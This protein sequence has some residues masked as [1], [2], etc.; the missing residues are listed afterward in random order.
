MRLLI[1]LVAALCLLPLKVLALSVPSLVSS[2]WLLKNLQDQQLAV[3]E[4]SDEASFDFEGHIPG[5]VNTNK[6]DWRYADKDGA[7]LHYSPQQLAEKIRTLGINHDDAVVIYYKGGDLNDVLGAFYLYWLFHYLGHTNV[8][9]LDQ[10]WHGWM[11]ANGP[12]EEASRT[13]SIGDF[14]ARPLAALEISLKELDEIRA[15]YLLIDGRFA[16]NFSGQKKFPANSLYGR[17]PGS[18]NFSWQEEYIRKS[19]DGHLYAQVPSLSTL[20]KVLGDE[21]DRP[22]LLICLGG[23]GAAVNYAMFYAAGYG[24]LRLNDAG[25]RGWNMR[26]LPLEKT[27]RNTL[28]LQKPSN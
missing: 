9:M 2:Q 6:S 27:E 16:A 20:K 28:K 25:F 4:V 12:V 15:H 1:I 21:P 10:G 14:I 3:I 24:N 23:T 17:I 7:L 13:I 5:S 8:G 22:I 19:V 18:A 11:K 26:G